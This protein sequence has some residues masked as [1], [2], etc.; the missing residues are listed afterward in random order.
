MHVYLF[1]LSILFIPHKLTR[2]QTY[3]YTSYGYFTFTRLLNVV[4]FS[5]LYDNNNSNMVPMAYYFS[6]FSSNREANCSPNSTLM[7]IRCI[8]PPKM[9]I[10][11]RI[12]SRIHLRPSLCIS[13]TFCLQYLSNL[14]PNIYFPVNYCFEFNFLNICYYFSLIEYL[15]F[16]KFISIA[17]ILQNFRLD[18][19]QLFNNKIF[20]LAKLF[21]RF[22]KMI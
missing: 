20:I 7:T 3:T 10:L 8:S 19:R 15:V 9:I 16:F 18:T 11:L 21:S 14:F 1:R 2:L 12:F 6:Y 5:M 13:Y 17:F 22:H 4:Q